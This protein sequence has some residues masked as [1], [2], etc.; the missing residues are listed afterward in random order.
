MGL[1][2]MGIGYWVVSGRVRVGYLGFIYIYI[3]FN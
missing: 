3:L 1:W 2:L